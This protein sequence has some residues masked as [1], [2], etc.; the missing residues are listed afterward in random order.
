MVV[1]LVLC[2][3]RFSLDPFLIE[4]IKSI[5][6]ILEKGLSLEFFGLKVEDYTQASGAKAKATVLLETLSGIAVF[7]EDYKFPDDQDIS[8][9]VKR[10]HRNAK[11]L[12]AECKE[13]LELLDPLQAHESSESQSSNS[14]V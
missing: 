8:E 11:Y 3:N 5:L 13:A 10:F 12:H 7:V 2:N 4:I 6:E 1:V 9:M 14:V